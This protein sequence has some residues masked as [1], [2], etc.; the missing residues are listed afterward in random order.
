MNVSSYPA[1]VADDNPFL[2]GQGKAKTIRIRQTPTGF[3]V[4]L[5]RVQRPMTDTTT[6]LQRPISQ[7]LLGVLGFAAASFLPAA[8][9]A[10]STAADYQSLNQPPWAPPSQ[11]FGPVWTAL[12]RSDGGCRLA[13]MA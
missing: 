12:Y 4:L 2:V 3:L 5:W 11:V 8:I 13:G 10:S 1:A 6:E 9:V 7:S